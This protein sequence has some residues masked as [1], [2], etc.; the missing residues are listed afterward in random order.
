MSY[1]QRYPWQANPQ[2]CLGSASIRLALI[3]SAQGSYPQKHQCLPVIPRRNYWPSLF[4][5]TGDNTGETHLSIALFLPIY[6]KICDRF[7]K[8]VIQEISSKNLIKGYSI[9]KLDV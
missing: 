8:S 1:F 7:H 6:I 5:N 9:Q 4:I 3:H 2:P